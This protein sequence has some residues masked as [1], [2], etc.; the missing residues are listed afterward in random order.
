MS[1]N[2]RVNIVSKQNTI[3]NTVEYSYD[4]AKKPTSQSVDN[5]TISCSYNKEG[6]I[7]TATN[8]IGRVSFSYDNHY[9]T[10]VDHTKTTE[11]NNPYAYTGRELDKV[12]TY[13]LVFIGG[14]LV[15]ITIA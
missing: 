7:L 5:D 13:T 8:T 14:V 4:N 11:T 10:I 2:P 3:N 15:L 1:L 6:N 12:R 9:G